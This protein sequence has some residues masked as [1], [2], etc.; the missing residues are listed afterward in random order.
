MYLYRG[1]GSLVQSSQLLTR[2]LAVIR[3]LIKRITNLPN[4]FGY[5]LQRNACDDVLTGFARARDEDERICLILV[6]KLQVAIG[7]MK[8]ISDGA[9]TIDGES[10]SGLGHEG[11]HDDIFIHFRIFVPK[12]HPFDEYSDR[13]SVVCLTKARLS[14]T[15]RCIHGRE[16]VL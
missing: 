7:T 14:F 16:H 2:V 13:E 1:H 5:L 6:V 9:R 10:F 8:P 3:D 4:P 15:Y 12:G 11:A